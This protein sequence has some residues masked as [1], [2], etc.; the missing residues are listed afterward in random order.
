MNKIPAD[1]IAP[2]SPT[3]PGFIIKEELEARKMKQKDL[4]EAMGI[5]VTM[6][7]DLINGRRN[8]TAELAL[9][10]EKNLDIPALFWL[11]YQAQYDIDLLR[12]AEPCS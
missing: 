8:V 1:T 6:F 9:K 4:A 7:S 12:K 3:H 5:S 11:N 10:L 2:G